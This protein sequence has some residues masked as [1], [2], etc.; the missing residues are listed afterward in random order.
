MKELQ[1]MPSAFHRLFPIHLVLCVAFLRQFFSLYVHQH[2]FC[3]SLL[4]VTFGPD[5]ASLW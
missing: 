4:M 5:L 2:T 1:C 3:H